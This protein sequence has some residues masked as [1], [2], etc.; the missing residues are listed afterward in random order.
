MV[1]SNQRLEHVTTFMGYSKSLKT[2]HNTGELILS[3]GVPL[4]Y[5]RDAYVFDEMPGIM[6]V[7]KVYRA[8]LRQP[9]GKVTNMGE[10]RIGQRQEDFD[11]GQDG[12]DAVMN[13][14]GLEDE[15]EDEDEDG[16]GDGDEDVTPQQ[17]EGE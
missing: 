16:D 10:I 8:P 12:W 2:Q 3:V 9:V 11:A 14:L 6:F 4:E 13:E 15:D 17:Q 5:R 1:T 7:I